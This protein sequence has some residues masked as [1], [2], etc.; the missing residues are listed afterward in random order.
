MNCISIIYKFFINIFNYNKYY[1]MENL[2]DLSD[3]SD[4]CFN[5]LSD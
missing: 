2:I 1:N 5:D 3:S 4:D